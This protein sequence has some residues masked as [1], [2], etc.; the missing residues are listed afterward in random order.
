[1]PLAPPVTTTTLSLI[2]MRASDEATSIGAGAGRA[3]R[4]RDIGRRR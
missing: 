3:K 2:S 1:M 4:G